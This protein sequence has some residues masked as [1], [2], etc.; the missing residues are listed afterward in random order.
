MVEPEWDF[1]GAESLDG[2]IERYK[3]E[4]IPKFLDLIV[5]EA[6]MD[7]YMVIHPSSHR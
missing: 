1:E 6:K 2:A 7:H 4:A 3:T 5:E